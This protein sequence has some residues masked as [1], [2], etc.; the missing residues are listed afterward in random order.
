MKSILISI[1]AVFCPIVAH[2]EPIYPKCDGATYPVKPFYRRAYFRSDGTAVSAGNVRGTCRA[3]SE[4]WRKW[5]SLFKGSPPD[6]WPKGEAAKTWTIEEQVRVIEAAESLP[7]FLIG[8]PI[9]SLNRF[10]TSKDAASNPEYYLFEPAKLKTVTP[11]AYDWIAQHFGDKLK[12][13]GGAK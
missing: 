5:N 2:A 4:V 9:L 12:T 13:S 7:S 1:A 8:Q 10:K 3:R 6:R 11:S